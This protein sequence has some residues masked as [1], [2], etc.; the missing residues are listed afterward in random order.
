MIHKSIVNFFKKYFLNCW[1]AETTCDPGVCSICLEECTTKICKCTFMHHECASQYFKCE[2]AQSC[3]ICSTRIKRWGL[4]NAPTISTSE[5]KALQE[6]RRLH[7]A[8][9][10]RQKH[11]LKSWSNIMFPKIIRFLGTYQVHVSSLDQALRQICE[12]E[13]NELS[14]IQYTMNKGMKRTKIDKH[15]ERL[16]YVYLNF[17]FLNVNIRKMLTA[18]FKKWNYEFDSSESEFVF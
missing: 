7:R 10:F 13:H 6:A 17:D 9:A 12:D 8:S 5:K 16:K 4:Q 15:I 18:N 1:Y 3:G 2:S 11:E 14:F